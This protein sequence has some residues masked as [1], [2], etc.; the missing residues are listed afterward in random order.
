MGRDKARTW[1][2][3]HTDSGGRVRH[4]VMVARTCDVDALLDEAVI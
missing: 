2:E 4:D 3:L 1:L